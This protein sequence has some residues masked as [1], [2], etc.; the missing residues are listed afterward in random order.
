[1]DG[2]SMLS[3]AAIGRDLVNRQ[4]ALMARRHQ[5]EAERDMFR[6]AIADMPQ[7]KKAGRSKLIDEIEWILDHA[8]KLEGFRDDAAHTPL[9]YLFCVEWLGHVEC[10]RVPK[11]ILSKS[12]CYS[13]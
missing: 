12:P 8:N 3:V 6:V 5:N 10:G 1:M 2:L 9:R 7:T 13:P 11:Y 4:L